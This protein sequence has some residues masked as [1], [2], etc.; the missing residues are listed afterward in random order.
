MDRKGGTLEF[1]IQNVYW[2]LIDSINMQ[3]CPKIVSHQWSL[4]PL[5]RE[6]NVK[7]ETSYVAVTLSSNLNDNSSSKFGRSL[8]SISSQSIEDILTGKDENW[9]IGIFEIFKIEY[10]RNS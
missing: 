6:Q 9:K 10:L 7:G 5:C 4:I 2:I 1:F 3:L 8:Y